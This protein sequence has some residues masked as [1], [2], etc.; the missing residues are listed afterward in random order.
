MSV[1]LIVFWV[2]VCIVVYVYAGY[3]MAAR[4]F[5][6]ISK[7]VDVGQDTSLPSVTV[8]IAAFNEEDVIGATVLNKLDQDYPSQLLDVV[9]VSDA[10][11]DDTDRI[12]RGLGERVTLVRQE[13]RAGKTAALNLGIKSVGGEILVFADANS[14]YSK[15]AIRNLVSVFKDPAVG[16]VTGRMVYVSADGSLIGD[17]CSAY[18][19]YENW[20]RIQES[21][22]GSVIGV[23]GGIDAMRTRLF[24]EMLPDQQSDFVQPLMVARQGYK[25]G[26]EPAAELREQA[27]DDQSAEYQMRVRVSLRALWVLWYMRE[28]M[29]PFKYGVFAW[30]L[31]SH[32]LIRYLAWIPLVTA[33]VSGVLLA[34]YSPAYTVLAG[35]QLSFYVAGG[36]GWARSG[37]GPSWLTVPYYFL[38]LNL[39]SAH[40]LF[41]FLSGEKRVVWAPRTG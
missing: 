19:R 11:E 36:I 16:Y 32:K 9:V 25:I 34:A 22:F 39:A 12:V 4:L 23:D 7:P 41:K 21:R 30:Q 37:K 17:G 13:R 8:L 1:L 24:S 10:S 14:M 29:N 6:A 26:F 27:L 31:V 5:A 2:S 15:Q 3:A 33:L 35:I 28:L 40:A 20:L 18:M 38:V